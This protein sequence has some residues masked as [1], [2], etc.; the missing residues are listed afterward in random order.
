MLA[1][2]AAVLV[3][4]KYRVHKYYREMAESGLDLS[5]LPP[6]QLKACRGASGANT[7]CQTP[8]GASSPA[9][10]AATASDT[11]DDSKSVLVGERSEYTSE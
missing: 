8:S 3:L 1:A 9:E 11:T 10:V 5:A 6:S 7:L 2:L 4:R